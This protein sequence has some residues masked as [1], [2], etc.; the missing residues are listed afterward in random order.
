MGKRALQRQRRERGPASYARSAPVRE[1]YDY[2]LIVCE[3]EKTEPLYFR[4]LKTAY[5]LSNANIEVVHAGGTDP[6]SIVGTAEDKASEEYDRIFCVFDRD[7]HANYD[8]ALSRV[9][10]SEQGMSGRITAVPSWPC[11]ELWLLLH[12]KYTSAAFVAGGGR[13]AC[14]RV[15]RELRR[16]FTSYTKGHETVFHDLQ[17]NLGAALKNAKRLATDNRKTGSRNPAT[18]MH[19][20]VGYLIALKK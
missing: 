17:G 11:F 20:L 19:E 4:G 6:M 7:G 13:S 2:V 1:R 14:D 18:A 16:E 12:F 10:K 5:R 9:A 3:G 15:L 8:A